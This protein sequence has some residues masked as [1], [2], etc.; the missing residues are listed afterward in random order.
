MRNYGNWYALLVG[1]SAVV[2]VLLPLSALSV[3]G[4]SE[5]TPP[6]SA[7]V[8]A[9]KPIETPVEKPADEP[10]ASTLSEDV[11]RVLESDG[12]T[13][14]EIDARTFLIWTVAAEMPAKFEEEALKAQVVAAY[15]Y[16]CYERAAERASPTKALAGA[17]FSDT[18]IAY[19]KGYTEAY[20]KERWGSGYDEYY[21]KIAAAVDAVGGK[22]ILY[23]GAPIFAAY[24]AISSGTTEVPE[25]VWSAAFPYLQS[26]DSQKDAAAPNYETTVTLSAPAFAKAMESVKGIDL[27]GDAK[28]WVKDDAKRSAAG[29][30]VSQTVGGVSVEGTEWRSRCKLR[31]ACFT[32]AY[33]DGDF[34]FHVKGYGHDVGMSQYGA[35][36]LAQSGYSWEEILHHY[37]SDVKIA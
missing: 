28:N 4:K 31:S 18:P 32:V 30:V 12:K 19:P 27:S 10:T 17:D 23:N 24:H 26:V 35:Q 21:Q 16:F 8:E 2:M 15:T 11:F 34:V 22:R 29:T 3:S 1:L 7:T 5:E 20:W 14:S 6:P 33:E 36:F 9:E 37:Y 25:V 13:V